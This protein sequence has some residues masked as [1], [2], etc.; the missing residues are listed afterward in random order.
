MRAGAETTELTTGKTCSRTLHA[1]I[2]YG[3]HLTEFI[4]SRE[5]VVAIQRVSAFSVPELVVLS[6]L[7]LLAGA[8]LSDGEDATV[9]R[10]ASLALRLRAVVIAAGATIAQER[11]VRTSWAPQG[12]RNFG[13]DF[14]TSD[15]C[16]HRIC[17]Q[18]LKKCLCNSKFGLASR[19]FMASKEKFARL[20]DPF[21]L[22]L[23]IFAIIAFM[24]FAGEVLK[25]LALSVLLSFALAPAVRYLER[26]GL[27]R[28]P[29]VILTVVVTLG[30]LGG[31]GYVVGEQLSSLANMLPGYQ[32]N[33]EQKLTRVFKPGEQ[34]T[35][36][37]LS[38][39]AE[40]RVRQAASGDRG[41]GRRATV[42]S[43]G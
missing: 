7:R 34:S 3:L 20:S 37:R 36:S 22:T 40:P 4:A 42:D 16:W 15:S 43:E 8:T 2:Q 21:K 25:P 12:Q 39:L 9:L 33:I 26:L 14:Q 18:N 13:L 27:P 23:L 24:Y 17:T 5:R 32:E 11:W 19:I 30:L 29:A 41:R 28:P 1:C 38:G 31:I 35:A 6:A 10:Q